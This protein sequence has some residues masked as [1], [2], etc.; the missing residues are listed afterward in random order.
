[1][2]RLNNL[3][4]FG[5]GG[6]EA[7]GHD[8][9]GQHFGGGYYMGTDG[10]YYYVCAPISGQYDGVLKWKTTLT[11]TTG[12][13]STTDGYANTAAMVTA[14]INDHP[15]G[16]FCV[17]LTING[18]SDWYLPSKD[19]LNLLY[20]NHAALETAGSGSFTNAYYCSSSE[21]GATTAWRQ[22][23]VSGGQNNANKSNGY[24]VRAIR[25]VAI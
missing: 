2:L 25:R 17:D 21:G 23:F 7:G 12:A 15:A 14:G 24:Y 9:I 3:I 1:M 19:E 8:Y 20:T 4:G 16:K 13:T 22:H 6:G 11:T 18:Y 10:T 5:V